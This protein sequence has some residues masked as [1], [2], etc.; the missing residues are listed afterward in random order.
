MVLEVL[1]VE[2]FERSRFGVLY[3]ADGTAGI[4]D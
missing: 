4:D 2:V 3:H 1:K